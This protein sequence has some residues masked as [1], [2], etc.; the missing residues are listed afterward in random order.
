MS[1]C[2]INSYYCISLIYQNT[3]DEFLGKL[4]SDNVDAPAYDAVISIERKLLDLLL[5]KRN[6][7]ERKGK[8]LTV[9]GYATSHTPG[10][11]CYFL[12]KL[13]IPSIKKIG[14]L[15]SP[16]QKYFFLFAIDILTVLGY[17]RCADSKNGLIYAELA[18]GFE[19]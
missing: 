12:F 9:V 4:Q 7:K 10:Y 18:L 17:I 8:S 13:W 6:S 14:L 5:Q 3:A 19:I 2:S 11:C 15:H 16:I 1:P